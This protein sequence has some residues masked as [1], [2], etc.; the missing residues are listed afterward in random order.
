MSKPCIFCKSDR[1]NIQAHRDV[2]MRQFAKIEDLQFTEAGDEVEMLYFYITAIE[3]HMN[4]LL[5]RIEAL[6]AV[7]P[8]P[9]EKDN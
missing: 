6:E 2:A 4:R 7:K 8:Q 1:L 5:E 3:S 9:T